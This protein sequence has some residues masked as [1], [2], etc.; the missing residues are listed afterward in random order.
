[1]AAKNLT[2]IDNANIVLLG[3]AGPAA[4][5]RDFAFIRKEIRRLYGPTNVMS[6]L[7]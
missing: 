6:S 3:P 1:M 4:A 7:R 5:Q 2:V